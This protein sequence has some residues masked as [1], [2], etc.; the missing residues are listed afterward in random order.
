MS[1]KSSLV[2]IAIKLTPDIVVIW[3]ANIILKGIA[4]MLDFMF[5]LDTR[6]AYVQMRLCGEVEPIEVSLDG[7]AIINEGESHQLIIQHA[8]ANRP[9]LNNLLSRLVGKAWTIPEIPRYKAQ[10]EL[11]S[12]LLKAESPEYEQE[13][14]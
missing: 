2:K 5:D 10:I 9:W 7:F 12:E 11:F 4:E 14:I 8:Q 1:I 6:T 3:V 13:D